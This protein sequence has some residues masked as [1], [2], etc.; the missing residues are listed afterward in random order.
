MVKT[1]RDPREMRFVTC[2]I[3]NRLY[4]KTGTF[5]YM[6]DTRSKDHIESEKSG[7]IRCRE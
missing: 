4:I 6:R 3:C 1:V 5:L 2:T 7:R